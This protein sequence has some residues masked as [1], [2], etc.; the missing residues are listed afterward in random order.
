MIRFTTIT[1]MALVALLALAACS[2]DGTPD[3]QTE[4]PIPEVAREAGNFTT[5][6]AA[7]E[8]AELAE[9]LSGPGP[10][11]VF[12]PTDEAFSALPAGTVESLLE[13]ENREQLIEVLTY[14]VAPGEY[15]SSALTSIVTL[16]MLNGETAAVSVGSETATIDGANIVGTDITASNG[17]VHVIDAVILPEM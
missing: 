12:A 4:S 17:L 11:T 5:L 13:P 9:S 10:F 8:A 3:L 2:G 15:P 1:G 6:L 14:H 16:K 7:I